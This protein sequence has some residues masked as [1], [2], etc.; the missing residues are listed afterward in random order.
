MT[1]VHQRIEQAAGVTP[2]LAALD[3][4][5][6]S[7]L[8]A[9][10][11]DALDDPALMRPVLDA[12]AVDMRDAQIAMEAGDLSEALVARLALSLSKLASLS[13]GLRT[14]SAQPEI[15]NS[16][17]TYRELSPGLVLEQRRHPLGVIGVVFEARPDALPQ[18]VG[19]ALKSGN[20]IVLKGGR[21]AART[22][23]AMTATIHQVL[24]GA[25]LPVAAVTLLEDRAEFRELL[26]QDTSV[27]LLIARGSGAFVRMV[28]DSTKIPV[29][30]HAEGLC[31]IYL[32]EDADPEMAA[33]VVVDAKT[34]YPAACNAV[35]TLLWHTGA[36]SAI[37]ATLAALHAR[38]V[39]LRGCDATMARHPAVRAATSDDWSVEY[40]DLVISVRA[41]ADANAALAHIRT[42]GS[43][44]TEAVITQ[45]AALAERFIQRV[46]AA[47]IFHN[48]STRFSDGLRFGLG[49]EVG[50]STG[51]LHA[52]GPVGVEG[53]MTTRWLLRGDGDL[54]EDFDTK[55]RAFTHRDLD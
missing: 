55:S 50:I 51:K 23:A 18:I 33:A 1:T 47:C 14:L 34:T 13:A 40:S 42:F 36:A 9:A 32:H 24:R 26:A 30:G 43:G 29:L 48:V 3:G 52:R 11:A 19:L 10:L 44:H 54:S 27:D 53:L 35:E 22:N 45:S 2:T 28:Q 16:R 21:E 25:N 15:V 6:R 17:I 41:V 20:A 31:H 8:L 7:A 46:D 49:G 39:Q 12:N 38:G 4:A 37:D 5:K